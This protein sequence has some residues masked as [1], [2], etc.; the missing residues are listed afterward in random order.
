MRILTFDLREG[1]GGS[2]QNATAAVHDA[3]IDQARRWADIQDLHRR[4]DRVEADALYQDDLVDQLEHMNKGK[5]DAVS[6]LFKTSRDV[7]M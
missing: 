7:G 5:T 6:K 4:I 2:W 3:T 1:G